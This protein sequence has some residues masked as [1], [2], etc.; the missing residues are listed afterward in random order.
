MFLPVSAQPIEYMSFLARIEEE[1]FAHMWQM[2][3]A[4]LEVAI[5][6][7]R[8]VCDH[9]AVVGLIEVEVE[10]GARKDMEIAHMEIADV[11]SLE[12]QGSTRNGLVVLLEVS[13]QDLLANF[14]EGSG[15]LVP[16][17]ILVVEDMNTQQRTS[18][19]VDVLEGEVIRS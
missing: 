13:V 3:D 16:I 11:H 9:L 18:V 14:G 6:R 12:E 15:A 2:K 17:G 19:E 10:E 1:R 5:V 7:R 4:Q 8:H